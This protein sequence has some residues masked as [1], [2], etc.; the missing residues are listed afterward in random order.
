MPL[1]QSLHTRLLHQQETLPELI[2]GF[3]EE[4]LR[5]RTNPD[6]WSIFENIAHLA[7]YQHVFTNRLQHIVEEQEPAFERYVGDHDPLFLAY[8]ER[9]LK[10]VLSDIARQRSHIIG[11]F[12]SYDEKLLQRS[13]LHPK[14]GRMSLLQ[15]TEFFLLHEAHHLFAIF[16]L[17][18][19]ADNPQP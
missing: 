15:W 16:I 11:L 19:T 12:D 18:R 13:G 6:K 17:T 1:S 7:V 10:E 9:S 4:R 8:R 5:Q 3:S 2:A 14:Y